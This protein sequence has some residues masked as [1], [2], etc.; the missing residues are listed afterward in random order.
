[1]KIANYQIVESSSDMVLIR[2]V[3]PLDKYMTVTNAAEQVVAEMILT[4][5]DRRLEYI[6][7]EGERAQL[8]VKGGKFAGF[9]PVS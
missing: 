7:S 1:M 3:G 6:D 4:L 8:L 9:A 5:A 2:N